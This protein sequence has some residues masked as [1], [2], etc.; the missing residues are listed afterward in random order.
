MLIIIIII[1][2]QIFIEEGLSHSKVVFIRVLW[3]KTLYL[4]KIKVESLIFIDN[5]LLIIMKNLLI[6][7]FFVHSVLPP[8]RRFFAGSIAGVTA[9]ALT[10]PL[11]MVRARLAVSRKDKYVAYDWFY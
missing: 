5:L 6:I 11:D 1:I 10:Y 3:F 2:I 9:V 7:N 8:A 4:H